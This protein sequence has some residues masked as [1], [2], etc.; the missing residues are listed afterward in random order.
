MCHMRV[1]S[2]G[3]IAPRLAL[4]AIMAYL[5]VPSLHAQAAGRVE[6]TVTKQVDGAPLGGVSV[7]VEGTGVSTVTGTDGQY[8][9]PRVPAGEQTIVFRWL[10]YQPQALRVTV[11]SGTTRTAD[12]ALQAQVINL[13]EIVVSAASR[14]PER[15][16]EAPSAM[17]VIDPVSL[18]DESITGQAP[19]ALTNV[20]GVD[21]V[22][23]GVQDYNVNARGFNS[24]LN[25]RVL[26]LQ[27]GRDLAIAFL[28]SQEWSALSLPLEDV[29]H[30]EMVR[31]PGSALYGANAFAGVLDI[32]TPPARDIAGTKL[33]LGGGE[34]STVRADLRHAGTSPDGRFGYKFNLGVYR[35][36][37]WD[38]SRTN[39]GDLAGEYADVTDSVVTAPIPGFELRP[40]DGQELTGPVGTPSE[41]TGDP[42]DIQN[43]YGSGRFDYYALDGSILTVEGGAA[44]VE[45]GVFV[46]GIGRV[47]VAKALRPWARVAWDSDNYNL[48]AWYSGRNSLD[49]QFSLAS[50]APLEETSAIFHV[51][52]QYNRS[53]AADRARIV[54]GASARSYNVNTDGTL[55]EP[56]DD[57]RSDG[58]YSGY[59]Q[60]E[61]DIV[62]Q[63]RAVAAAR[64]D[65]GDLFTTQFSP[66]GALVFSPNDQ[67]S[68]RFSVNRAFQTPNYSEFFLRASTFGD[69]TT[70][71]ATLEAGLET[72]YATVQNP[73]AVGPVL[74]GAMAT[75]GLSD[76]SWNFDAETRALALG[77]PDL[78]VEKTTAWELGYKGNISSRAYVSIDLYLS[79]IDDFVSDLLPAAILPAGGTAKYT[80]Y[81][82]TAGGADVPDDLDAI[83]QVLIGAGLPPNHPL[84]VNLEA[85]R[86]GYTSL[87]QQTSPFL[88]TLP[89]G[90]RAL[91][92]SYG[93]AGEVTERGVEFGF[94][95]GITPEV[96]IDLAYTFFDFEVDAPQF[97]SELVPNTPEHKGSIAVS[98]NGV[99]GLDLGVE[100]RFVDSYRWEAGVF[101]GFVPSRQTVDLNAGY[102]VNNNLRLFATATNVFDQEQYQLFGG[103]VLGRRVLGGL[104]A[105]F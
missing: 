94:G 74:A 53:F 83:E 52:G 35:S 102:R 70:D 65:G 92:V 48:M 11:Q 22:Q 31:G 24:S 67:H 38:R 95:Y 76:P 79:T 103:S 91:V 86:T 2:K 104:T 81:S 45:N 77:N 64:V 56:A 97:G 4:L 7:V 89:A 23:S 1:G 18:R 6:G 73:A 66:K 8:A 55:M 10:G 82:L 25:R 20:P 33:S 46:T 21:V 60:I 61:V 87:A 96:R 9:L 100:G 28:G 16:V 44:Q 63:L 58:Y 29:A 40:L 13:G 30:M 26:V 15:I 5:G 78:D 62:P 69:R 41:A 50:G 59:G 71:P 51:E 57:D 88:A 75:L 99:E 47:Q 49:P 36:E 12:V 43:V 14:T 93:N 34:L 84:R 27:D 98:Y 42:D 17:T 80:P 32:R 90:N 39:L 3:R 37:S 105:T 19:E 85:L 101:A 72:Y 68:I 54:L